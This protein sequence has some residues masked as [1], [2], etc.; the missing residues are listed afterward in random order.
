MTAPKNAPE[1]FRL[2]ADDL[3]SPTWHRLSEYLEKRLARLREQNDGD[4]SEADTAKLRGRIA[5]LKL[6]LS[7]SKTDRPE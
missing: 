7:L 2:G 4:Q 6:I 1:K 5:E 3:E